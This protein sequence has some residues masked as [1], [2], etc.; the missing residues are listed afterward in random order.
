MV[1]FTPKPNYKLLKKLIIREFRGKTVSI[2]EIDKFVLISGFTHFKK[3]I[4]KPMEEAEE[5]G[6][7]EIRRKRRKD[8]YPPG[9]II[10]FW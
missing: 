4:L 8:T 6:I 10:Q 3:H 2:E 7:V 9:T 5:I 1:L